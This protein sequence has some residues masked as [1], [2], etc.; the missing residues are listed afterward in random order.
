[1]QLDLE[2]I[3]ISR[4]GKLWSYT[5]NYYLPPPPYIPPDP[6]VSYGLAVVELEAEKMMIMGQ[7]ASS[8]DLETLQ[9]G[10]DMELIVEKLFCD[11]KGAEHVIW[12]WRPTIS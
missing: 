3:Q 10:M 2:D 4:K 12:K 5:V 1:M 11:D 6:F 7:V 8:C 9:I